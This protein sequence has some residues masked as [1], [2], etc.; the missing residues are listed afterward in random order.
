M[1]GTAI[2]HSTRGLRLTTSTRSCSSC[3]L[4]TQRHTICA[5]QRRLYR[6]Q[7]RSQ[8]HATT[9]RIALCDRVV[10]R[11]L[12]ICATALWLPHTVTATSRAIKISM[13]WSNWKSSV[14]RA[15]DHRNDVYWA[16]N[17]LRQRLIVSN[18]NAVAVAIVID[19]PW[20]ITRRKVLTLLILLVCRS[21]R[22]TRPSPLRKLKP[23]VIIVEDAIFLFEK[24]NSWPILMTLSTWR[25]MTV[26]RIANFRARSYEWVHLESR[27]ILA[28]TSRA[29]LS[30]P[31]MTTLLKK[32]QECGDSLIKVLEDRRLTRPLIKTGT[33][34]KA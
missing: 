8:R 19:K 1:T 2:W 28:L 12:W 20:R 5:R 11:N 31:M 16:K 18:R 33:C 9:I 30:W 32:R 25:T 21:L 34:S 27:K 6:S 15:V 14:K 24:V 22:L 13:A 4:S 10:R 3:K 29:I 17:S 26:K 7:S 23:V